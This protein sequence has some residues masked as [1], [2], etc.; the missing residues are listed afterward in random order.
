VT[1]SSLIRLNIAAN[2]QSE[3]LLT[4]IPSFEAL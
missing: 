4:M 3:Y 1:N 2:I